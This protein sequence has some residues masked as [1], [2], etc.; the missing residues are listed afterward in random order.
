MCIDSNNQ[1]SNYYF[2]NSESKFEKCSDNCNECE[3]QSK[4]LECQI[5]YFL[6]YNN[7]SRYSCSKCS[8]STNCSN[9]F[10]ANKT[11][12]IDLAI[13][14][15]IDSIEKFN[16]YKLNYNWKIVCSECPLNYFRKTDS[17]C[18]KCADEIADCVECIFISNSNQT[19]EDFKENFI[20]EDLKES[21][22]VLCLI[23]SNEKNTFLQIEMKENVLYSK[24]IEC[25]NFSY[26]C[27]TCQNHIFVDGMRM[28]G[29]DLKTFQ[30]SPSFNQASF[31]LTI[32]CLTCQNKYYLDNDQ[33]ICLSCPINCEFCYLDT[34]I[35]CGR[36]EEGYVLS[37]YEG[38]CY[39]ISDFKNITNEYLKSC[40]RII[41]EN[42]FSK[43]IVDSSLFLCQK[44]QDS[45][46]YPSLNGRCMKCINPAC[47]ECE[48]TINFIGQS[49]NIKYTNLLYQY[50]FSL[51]DAIKEET[52][53]SSIQKCLKCSS[54]ANGYDSSNQVCCVPSLDVSTSQ[55][56]KPIISGCQTC[57]SCILLPNT[58]PEKFVCNICS[59]CKNVS[60][61]FLND[62]DNIKSVNHY[63]S[64]FAKKIYYLLMTE[65][66]TF[67]TTP[68]LNESETFKNIY[69]SLTFQKQ[70]DYNAHI[71]K[72]CTPCPINNIDCKLPIN[73]TVFPDPNPFKIG[74]LELYSLL[75]Y[76]LV[77]TK[78]R[79]NFIFDYYVNSARCKFCPNKWRNC[80]AYKTIEIK[81]I[82]S[83]KLV[84][85]T[86][87]VKD[88]TSLITLL[89]NLEKS[90]FAFI[91]NEF[92]VKEIKIY[93]LLDI[94]EA[95]KW[96]NPE[97]NFLVLESS[98][99]SIIPSL[100]KYE[101]IFIP[102]DYDEN[103]FATIQLNCS[104]NIKGYTLIKFINIIFKPKKSDQ[105]ILK[106][107]NIKLTPYIE[108]NATSILLKNCSLKV[109]EIV[110]KE[111][112]AGL[113][114]G[115][116]AI[117][118][119]SFLLISE[120][121]SIENF[122]IKN[123]IFLSNPNPGM[124]TIMKFEIFNVYS[125]FEIKGQTIKLKN[126]TFD[127]LNIEDIFSIF[128]FP[129]F[130]DSLIKVENINILD[131]HFFKSIFFRLG[132]SLSIHFKN[133]Y[134]NNTK[135]IEKPIITS[136]S[137][138]IES[139]WMDNIKI[140][141]CSFDVGDADVNY[142]FSLNLFSDTKNIVIKDS[143][144][145]KTILF[146]CIEKIIDKAEITYSLFQNIYFSKNILKN[147]DG[148]FP[149]FMSFEFS[150][151]LGFEIN[152]ENLTLENN[153][154]Q[155]LSKIHNYAIIFINID[156]IVSKNLFFFNNLN[157]SIIYME[158]L[159]SAQFNILTFAKNNSLIDQ[160]Q[161]L[162]I[163]N[164]KNIQQVIKLQ[165]IFLKSMFVQQGLIII[166]HDV[167]FE[168]NICQVNFENLNF[169]NILIRSL[170][171]ASAIFISSMINIE[172]TIVESIFSDLIL[173]DESEYQK[174]SS[175]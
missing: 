43:Y 5:G 23:C 4:C 26:G 45:S 133:L 116:V 95:I 107:N 34:T 148:R 52:K 159:Y 132:G 91:C 175:I 71:I 14:D 57:S 120:S 13:F 165:N 83:S 156:K 110:Q 87:M 28:E 153:E 155:I 146:F 89:K 161:D 79:E 85:E 21:Y 15:S 136:L 40:S 151:I 17:L 101:L 137:E 114:G 125:I 147:F 96:E 141:N 75:S 10:I 102:K 7:A 68:S 128:N 115:E 25:G 92:F 144:F 67:N 130:E 119:L 105:L 3:S 98:L 150:S 162:I 172:I 66:Q 31:Y 93:I 164:M 173:I 112:L 19:L 168:T 82:S 121:V 78:C 135:F 88:L 111:Q 59:T 39:E 55:G 69:E 124:G 138:I 174:S 58:E 53:V 97:Q 54:V 32:T 6:N 62:E 41:S 131:C 142:V 160:L 8:D 1:F 170:N 50:P 77:A 106:Q 145:N 65:G 167:T 35:R 18:Y 36:C 74:D 94:N 117:K 149:F 60:E 157:I 51:L 104:I 61:K 37:F 81:F 127:S 16:S 118:M 33:S 9:C 49:Q 84:N 171:L 73:L 143:Y 163:F 24:C 72:K 29:L 129:A 56:M 20:F 122:E 140:E 42:P 113:A 108:I 80:K 99:K 109:D 152:I 90:E 134:I 30:K 27:I 63:S 103:T 169:N 123:Y 70:I 76:F 48:E 44:C 38:K 11:Q 86:L 158:N 166:S 139:V 154:I 64:F 22:T 12:K 46:Y 100:E 47:E 126:F 2:D